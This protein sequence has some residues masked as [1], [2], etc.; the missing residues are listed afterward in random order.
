VLP[1][2][3]GP[4]VGAAGQ[5]SLATPSFVGAHIPL[6]AVVRIAE[7][8]KHLSVQ[9]LSQQTPSTQNPDAH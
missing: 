7:Q 1:Q 9:G 2:A 4:E 6:G 5:A 8:E 3:L